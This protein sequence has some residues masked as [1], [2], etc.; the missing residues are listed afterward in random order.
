MPYEYNIIVNRRISDMKAK[1]PIVTME[2]EDGGKIVIE[3]YPEY[4]PNT[5]TNFLHL[6]GKG[7][8]DGL[9][10]HRVIPDFM[11]Q[12]GDP[13]GTGMGGPNYTIRG[14]F[15]NNGFTVNTLKHTRGVI[16]MARSMSPNS[17]GSQFFIMHA[18]A[19]H[20]DGE[21][22]AFGKVTEG[23]DTVDKI[24]QSKTGRA[25]KPVEKQVIKNIKC[26]TYGIDYGAPDI[27][28]R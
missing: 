1:N 8:Y 4:A 5:V 26:E 20:L 6:A 14:E 12:G 19:P 23:M 13:A 28:K 10:F 17:A 3:L 18:D 7:F 11:I 16:S 21:Y 24:A 15:K 2:I 22:A 25:D 27:L 9:T